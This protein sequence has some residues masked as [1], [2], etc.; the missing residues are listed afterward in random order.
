MLQVLGALCFTIALAVEMIYLMGVPF[1]LDGEVT[2]SGQM[3]W[4]A[5]CLKCITHDVCCLPGI[6]RLGSANTELGECVAGVS[7]LVWIRLYTK[8]GVAVCTATPCMGHLI[9]PSTQT[10]GLM[11]HSRDYNG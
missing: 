7:R 3:S 10:D 5:P 9:N 2:A 6:C 4:P 11:H 8:N 1:L